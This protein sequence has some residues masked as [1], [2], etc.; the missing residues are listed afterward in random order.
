MP[1]PRVS[2]PGSEP[3]NAASKRKTQLK[4]LVCCFAAEGFTLS[5]R[6]SVCTLV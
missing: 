4:H 2:I 6:Q 3:V 1:L 5:T